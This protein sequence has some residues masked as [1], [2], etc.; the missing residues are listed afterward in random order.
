M[1]KYF[2]ATVFLVMLFGMF[3]PKS[4]ISNS[5]IS[6][7]RN[8]PEYRYARTRLKMEG[9]GAKE[10]KQAADAI[11]KFHKAQQYRQEME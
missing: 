11:Y 7:D 9:F 3:V 6:I 8:S 4:Q 10:S 5:D 1:A 2:F